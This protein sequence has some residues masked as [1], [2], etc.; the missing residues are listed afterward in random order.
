M[1]RKVGGGL[2][3]SL[4]KLPAKEAIT[5]LYLRCF[6]RYP[7]PEELAHAEALLAADGTRTEAIEDLLWALLNSRE[8]AFNH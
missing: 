6:A 3:S 8:F 5:E 1:A 4:A 7:D 2:A